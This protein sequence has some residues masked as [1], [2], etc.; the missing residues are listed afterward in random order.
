MVLVEGALNHMLHI[1]LLMT[2][3]FIQGFLSKQIK[4]AK[5][6]KYYLLCSDGREYVT[7]ALF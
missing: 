7:Q 6:N 5:P 3:W 4:P 1:K 2:D